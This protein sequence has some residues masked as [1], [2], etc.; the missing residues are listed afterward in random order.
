[1]F[2]LAY[3]RTF[4]GFVLCSPRDDAEMGLLLDFALRHDGPVGIRYPRANCEEALPEEPREAIALGRGEWLQRGERVALVGYG[5]MTQE[6]LGA[7]RRIEQEL[8][9]R[10][11]VV[12]ARFAKPVD[13]ALLA[14][15]AGSHRLLVTIEDHAI[16]GGFGSACL[17]ELNTR[18]ASAE[19][20]RIGVPDQFI[21]HMNSPAEQHAALG[22]D[23]AGIARRVA[24]RIR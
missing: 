8:G 22:M 24:E 1:M 4:P 5:S 16:A 12:N 18:G 23:A 21:E 9:F 3:L 10:P 14:E 6:A 2:D 17:E 15:L 13:G 11:S 20:L 7:G 19:L